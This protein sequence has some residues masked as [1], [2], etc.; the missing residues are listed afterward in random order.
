LMGWE[1]RRTGKPARTLKNGSLPGVK[2]NVQ[3][4][5]CKVDPPKLQTAETKRRKLRA[6]RKKEFGG[7]KSRIEREEPK[8]TELKSGRRKK[9]GT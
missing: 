3:L 7:L 2:P 8:N 9:R 6:H 4:S 1:K 5:L